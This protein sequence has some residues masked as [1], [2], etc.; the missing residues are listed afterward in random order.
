MSA[1]SRFALADV[2]I[3]LDEALDAAAL[4]PTRGIARRRP[5]TCG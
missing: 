2:A 4:L 1:R 5:S 3:A